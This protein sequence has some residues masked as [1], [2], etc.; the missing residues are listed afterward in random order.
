MN[1]LMKI[2][3]QLIDKIMSRPTKYDGSDGILVKFNPKNVYGNEPCCCQKGHLTKFSSSTFFCKTC[4]ALQLRRRLKVNSFCK[5]Y[6]W[7]HTCTTCQQY[8]T[9]NNPRNGIIP[10][11]DKVNNTP[12]DKNKGE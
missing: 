2:P 9:Y 11:E 5:K 3:Y 12:T 1:F 8:G 6:G 7:V 4:N 10:Q